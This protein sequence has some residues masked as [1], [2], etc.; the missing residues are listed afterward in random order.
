MFFGWFSAEELYSQDT[1]S[2]ITFSIT[3][4]A[5]IGFSDRHRS[6]FSFS[7]KFEIY[8]TRSV[9]AFGPRLLAGDPSGPWISSLVPFGRSGRVTHATVIE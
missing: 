7:L 6:D 9:G 4:P 3:D 5:K 1:W 8:K 2:V